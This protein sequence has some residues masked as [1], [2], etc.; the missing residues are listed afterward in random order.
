M[1]NVV[2][3]DIFVFVDDC[4]R[5]QRVKL[6]RTMK[7][8]MRNAVSIGFTGTPLFRNDKQISLEVFGRYILTY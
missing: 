8:T 3:G 1:Q 7:A 5:T 6:H 2:V 4:H